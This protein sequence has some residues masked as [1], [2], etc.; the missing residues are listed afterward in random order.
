M[1]CDR[2]LDSFLHRQWQW[3]MANT[4][5]GRNTL[6][7]QHPHLATLTRT[8]DRTKVC[9]IRFQCSSTAQVLST[10]PRVTVFTLPLSPL[11][12]LIDFRM[13]LA[14]ILCR[15]CLAVIP[16][17]CLVRTLRNSNRVN[18]FVAEQY[19]S[20]YGPCGPWATLFQPH[21]SQSTEGC[22]AVK[23]PDQQRSSIEAA[24]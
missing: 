14:S 13:L 12:L 24:G 16:S 1:V 8:V 21:A 17:M 10:C 5:N 3:N 22:E 20:M 2:L 9:R 23:C 18:C 19:H 4:L 11:I 15:G 6:L 7:L